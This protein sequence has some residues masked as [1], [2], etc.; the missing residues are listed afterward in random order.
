MAAYK[1][2]ISYAERFG[3]ADQVPKAVPIE[4]SQQTH[5]VGSSCS[6]FCKILE[7]GERGNLL[8]VR[9]IG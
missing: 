4:F 1:V 3:N 2:G 9:L 7:P 6:V 5:A 8:K